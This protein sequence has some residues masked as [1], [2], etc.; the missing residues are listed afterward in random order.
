MSK[1]SGVVKWFS[2]LIGYGYINPDDGDKGDF[3]PQSVTDDDG[4]GK[5]LEAN[6]AESSPPDQNKEPQARNGPQDAE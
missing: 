5:S 3:S 6:A 1:K 2:R 4:L